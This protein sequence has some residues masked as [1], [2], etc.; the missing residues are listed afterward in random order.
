MGDALRLKFLFANKDG[1]QLEMNFSKAATVAEAKAQL[2]RSWPQNVPS[3]EDAKSVRLICMGRGILQDAHSLESAVP[4]FDT[5]PTPVNVSVFHKSQEAVGEPT[6]RH[7][8]AKTVDSAGC[9][10][11]IC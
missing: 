9:G 1:V 5:H 8:I 10:C 4:V 7:A 3:A 11:V 2:M 6:R